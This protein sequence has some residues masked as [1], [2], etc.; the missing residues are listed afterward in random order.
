MKVML[1]NDLET[2]RI[3]FGEFR[4]DELEHLVKQMV[5]HGVSCHGATGKFEEAQFVVTHDEPTFFEIVWSRD[6]E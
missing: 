4:P 6:D 5:R 2:E 3:L 1:R